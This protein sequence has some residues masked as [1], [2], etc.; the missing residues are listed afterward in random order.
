MS[1]V[2][3]DP[4]LRLSNSYTRNV[5]RDNFEVSDKTVIDHGCHHWVNSMIAFTLSLAETFIVYSGSFEKVVKRELS[6]SLVFEG[7]QAPVVVTLRENCLCDL[8][9]SSQFAVDKK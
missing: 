5:K 1:E 3:N 4:I 7:Q 6:H 9:V 8:A 2:I